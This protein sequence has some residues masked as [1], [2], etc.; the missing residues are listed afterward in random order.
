M[1]LVERPLADRVEALGTAGERVLDAIRVVE[2]VGLGVEIIARA[3][4]CVRLDL[5][6]GDDRV[7]DAHR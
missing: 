2:D 6:G 5:E 4:V 7:T 3:R 1:P